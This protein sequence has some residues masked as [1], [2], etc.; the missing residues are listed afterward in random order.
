[1]MYQILIVSRI[2]EYLNNIRRLRL[3][4]ISYLIAQL[5]GG[6]NMQGMFLQ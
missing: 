6:Y 3:K 5:R 2:P 1:M 4:V